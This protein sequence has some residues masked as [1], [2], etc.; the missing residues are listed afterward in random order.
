VL[1]GGTNR[2]INHDFFPLVKEGDSE[3][4]I[5][6]AFV[7]SAPMKLSIYL[8]KKVRLWTASSY[9]IALSYQHWHGNEEV[10]RPLREEIYFF[11]FCYFFRI[12]CFFN[13]IHFVYL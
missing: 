13:T 8:I 10:D 3:N 12:I 4:T 6:G 1:A 7:S 5:R 2:A 11:L 9:S